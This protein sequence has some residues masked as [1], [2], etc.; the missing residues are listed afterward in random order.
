MQ[1]ISDR[2]L[3]MLL[4]SPVSITIVSQRALAAPASKPHSSQVQIINLN[5]ATLEELITLKGIGPSKAAE[6]L[7]FRNHYGPFFKLMN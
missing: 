4:V 1:W 3:P 2:L 6:I 5:T 7:R